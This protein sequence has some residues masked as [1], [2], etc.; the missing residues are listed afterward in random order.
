M[1]MQKKTARSIISMILTLSLLLTGCGT[2]KAPE[3]ATTTQSAAATSEPSQAI[4]ESTAAPR[5]VLAQGI[6]DDEIL[7]GST[8]GDSGNFAAIGVPALAAFEAVLNRVNANGGI[9]GRKLV[10]VHYDDQ[11]D[12]ANA[13]ALT[14]KLVEEDKV[15]ALSLEGSPVIISSLDYIKQQGIPLVYAATGLNVLYSENTPE[16]NIF[17]VQPE[18]KQDGRFL[19]ARVFHEALFGANKDQKLAPDAMIGVMYANNDTGNNLLEGVMA[20]AE[21]EGKTNQIIAE[22]VTAD[23]YATA[24]QKFKDQGVG[25]VI[26]LIND[27]KGVVAAMD[28]TQ[29][30]VP[31]LGYYGASANTAWSAETYKPTRP[32]YATC[33]ADYSTEKAIAALEDFYDALTYGDIDEATKVS[34]KENNYARAGY[35]SA[36]VLTEGLKRLEASGMDYSWEN[37][38]KCMEDGRFDLITGSYV[39]FSNGQRLGSVEECLFEYYTET[40]TDGKPAIT[41]KTILPFETM[42]V[43][44]AK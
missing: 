32:M 2:G 10:L 26:M 36:I 43:I 21:A 8:F 29:F 27:G 19:A 28:D 30:E 31:V 42:D 4:A 11:W 13:K 37:F 20:E 18:Y 15:F 22:V 6:T 24:I 25:V 9:G 41:A 5:Q 14:E 35:I 3:T 1:G 12:A 23:T 17:P 16:S 40:G 39:D 33:W 7:I 38:I 44:T 34:Y